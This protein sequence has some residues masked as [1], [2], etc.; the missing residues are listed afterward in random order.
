[1]EPTYV[2]YREN[3][4]WFESKVLVETMKRYYAAVLAEPTVDWC[5]RL[6]RI[7]ISHDANKD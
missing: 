2:I 5:V 1:M 7:L 3:D 4:L 6:E